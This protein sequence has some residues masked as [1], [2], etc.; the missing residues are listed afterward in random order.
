[1]SER[2]EFRQR[3]KRELVRKYSTDAQGNLTF[4]D[5]ARVHRELDEAMNTAGFTN[6][7]DEPP[8][9]TA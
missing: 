7:N 4:L 3:K 1:M 5:F 9:A 2:E 6:N 8:P